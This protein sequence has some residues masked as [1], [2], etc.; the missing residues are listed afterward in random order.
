MADISYDILIR[1]AADMAALDRVRSNIKGLRSDLVGINE[2]L[3]QNR[4]NIALSSWGDRFDVSRIRAASDGTSQLATAGLGVAGGFRAAAG[5]IL[6]FTSVA[7]AALTGITL[8]SSTIKRLNRDL[9]ALINEVD[10]VSNRFGISGETFQTWKVILLEAGQSSAALLPALD[11]LNQIIGDA[12]NKSVPAQEQLAKVGL[13]FEALKNAT[14]EQRLELIA[15][16]LS[17]IADDSQRAA[18][19]QDLLGRGASQL[20]PLLQ[21]LAAGGIEELQK[22]YLETG[23]ILSNDIAKKL[24]DIGDKSEAAARRAA[25]S[26][27]TPYEVYTRVKSTL[28]EILTTLLSTTNEVEIRAADEASKGGSKRAPYTVGGWGGIRTISSSGSSSSSSGASDPSSSQE[29]SGPAAPSKSSPIL[30]KIEEDAKRQIEADANKERLKTELELEIQLAAARKAALQEQ[31]ERGNAAF[32]EAQEQDRLAAIKAKAIQQAEAERALN[33]ALTEQANI[34]SDIESD[35]AR[36]TLEKR[37]AL[38][39]SLIEE[40]RLIAERLA[41]LARERETADPIRRGQIDAE[42][43]QLGDRARGNNRVLRGPNPTSYNDSFSAVTASLNDQVGSAPQQLSQAWGQAAGS[44]RSSM[45]SAFADIFTGSMSL[46]QAVKAAPAMIGQAFLQSGA[47]M[48]ADWVWKHVFMASVSKA[49][50]AVEIATVGSAEAAKTGL[51]GAGTAARMAAKTGETV[52]SVAMTGVETTVHTVGE[53]KKTGV[54][55]LG[56]IARKGIMIGETIFHGIQVVFRTGA[57]IASEALKTAASV[58]GSALR[59]PVI[60][61]ESIAHVFQ[62]GVGALAAM[63]HIPYVGP[64]LAIGAMGAIVAAGMGLVGKIGKHADGGIIRG[65]GTATSDSI[66]A[67]LSNGEAVIP[68]ARVSQYGESFIQGLIDGRAVP[69]R[70]VAFASENASQAQHSYAAGGGAISIG[71]ALDSHFAARLIGSKPG[72]KIVANVQSEGMREMGW[73]S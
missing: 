54:S 33:A 55:F 1:S 69:A 60:L 4:G 12:G 22:K 29:G 48:A 49:W 43:Q 6:G 38:I 51:T 68:A 47:Q 19:A 70:T 18:V 10:E 71:I 5:S 7:T 59:I 13:T 17:R 62:A 32:L 44:I 30:E 41:L 25:V 67:R 66:V 15:R 31:I 21:R 14:K 35:W 3:A 8:V 45:Q 26:W 57:H 42:S 39:A 27:A 52:H 40:N 46:A 11:R 64:I 53:T 72:R 61:A 2:M 24:D 50:H 16:G 58:A 73:E 63:A 28:G 56:S 20:N 23:D 9:E 34:R 37:P 36:T 65:P